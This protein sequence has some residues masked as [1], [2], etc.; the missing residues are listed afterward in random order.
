MSLDELQ[1]IEPILAGNGR[2][3]YTLTDEKWQ[4]EFEV[5][6][7]LVKPAKKSKKIDN[8]F[9]KEGSHW[10]EET[11]GTYHGATNWQEYASYINDV[12]KTIRHGEHD[13]CYF[14]YQIMDLLQFHHDDLRTKY[15]PD[16]ECWEVWI[17]KEPNTKRK[18]DEYER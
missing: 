14:H 5:R 7:G 17:E 8:R 13:Y 4:K 9:S 15:R 12:L 6:K 3:K 11:Q 18:V 10:N 16:D 2:P 1:E